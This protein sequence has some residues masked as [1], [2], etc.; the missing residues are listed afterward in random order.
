[1]DQNRLA[2]GVYGNSETISI[3]VIDWQPTSQRQNLQSIALFR[4]SGRKFP[5][6][7]RDNYTLLITKLNIAQELPQSTDGGF[8]PY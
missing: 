6:L 7:S 4:E 2:A 5:P 1:M 8:K 3:T